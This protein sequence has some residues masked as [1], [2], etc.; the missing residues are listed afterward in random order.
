MARYR[1]RFFVETCLSATENI[2][3]HFGDHEVMFL[4]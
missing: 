3:F 1:M 4:F 2:L